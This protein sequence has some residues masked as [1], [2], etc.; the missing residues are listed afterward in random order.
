MA[1]QTVLG[2]ITHRR[3][4]IDAS[5]MLDII[6]VSLPDAQNLKPPLR[7]ISLHPRNHAAQH[8]AASGAQKGSAVLLP[9]GALVPQLEC[10]VKEGWSVVVQ[11]VNDEVLL[12]AR[13]WFAPGA[14][15]A[16]VEFEDRVLVA[17]YGLFAGVEGFADAEAGPEDSG[18]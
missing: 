5:D 12:A 11:V 7:S 9:Q 14:G 17:P 1:Y 16:S 2:H 15:D 4:G 13:L 18:V 8:A 6:P 10:T 3:L